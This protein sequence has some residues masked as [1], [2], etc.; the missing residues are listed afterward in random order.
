VTNGTTR[1]RLNGRSKVDL[2]LLRDEHNLPT[3]SYDHGGRANR[4]GRLGLSNC[5]MIRQKAKT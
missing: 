2:T 3:S 5:E 1:S 4:A